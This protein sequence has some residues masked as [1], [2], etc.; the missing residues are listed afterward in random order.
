VHHE[1]TLAPAQLDRLAGRY[2]ISPQLVLTVTRKDGYLLLKENQELPE[3]LFPEGELQFFSKTSDDVIT[4]ELDASGLPA[5]F[6]I[7][8]GGQSIAVDRAK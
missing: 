3:E 6:V 8:T 2:A 1:L 7:H 4:F 5:R